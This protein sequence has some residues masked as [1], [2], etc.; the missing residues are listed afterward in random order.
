MNPDEILIY[1]ITDVANLPSILASDGLHSDAVMAKQNPALVIGYD[2]MKKR[3]LQELRVDCCRARFVGE[4][5]PFYFCPRSPMLFTINKGNVEGRPP[6]CQRTIVHLVSTLQ[7]GFATGSDWAVSSGNAGAYHTTFDNQ[8]MAVAMLDWDSI[9]AIS[10]QGRQHQKAAEFLLADHFPW[11]GI[12][13]IGCY[14]SA[15]ARQ[16]SELL[17]NAEHKPAVGVQADWYYQ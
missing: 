4:F 7:V 5:V 2:H 11:S 16:V 15:V 9:N 12:Q 8:L 13:K 3:R 10:W 17:A 1:H 14:N 6:G